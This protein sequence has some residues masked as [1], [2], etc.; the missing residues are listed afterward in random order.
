MKVYDKFFYILIYLRKDEDK[1]GSKECPQ[2]GVGR[3]GSHAIS[4]RLC[5][6]R[7]FI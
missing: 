5:K 2:L 4:R 6:P 7:L 3:S 1:F